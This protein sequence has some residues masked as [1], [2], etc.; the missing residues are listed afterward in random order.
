[1]SLLGR[2][3][4]YEKTLKLTSRFKDIYLRRLE[5]HLYIQEVIY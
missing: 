5:I 4:S 3:N 2:F 1:V